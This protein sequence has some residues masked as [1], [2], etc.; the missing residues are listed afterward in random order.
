MLI[1]LANI[2]FFHILASYFLFKNFTARIKTEQ[3][4]RIRLTLRLKSM[5]ATWQESQEAHRSA[6]TQLQELQSKMSQ[7]Q[8]K[9]R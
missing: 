7:L 2:L 3:R 4:Q 1:I 8:M 5:E 9:L 6:L